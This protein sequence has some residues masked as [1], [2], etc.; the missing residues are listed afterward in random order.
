VTVGLGLV[1]TIRGLDFGTRGLLL[2]LAA[3]EPSRVA[4]ALA[5]EV[6]VSG[7]GGTKTVEA[8]EEITR[9]AMRLAKKLGDP[10]IEGLAMV[11]SG[12][13]ADL[14]GDFALGRER[15]ERGERILR[16]RCRGV[17][18]E[19]DTAITMLF[20]DLLFLGDWPEIRRRLPAA[21]EGFAAR[22]DLYAETNVRSRMAWVARLM[23]DQPAQARRE[24]TEAIARWSHKSFHLQHYWQLTGLAEIALYEG[25]GIAAWETVA[26]S[27]E[28]F[29]ATHLLRVQ[30]TRLEATHLRLRT[31]V[32]AMAE[33]GLDGELYRTLQPLVARELTRLEAEQI[34]WGEGLTLLLR[35]GLAA[36][37]GE[38]EGAAK[39]LERA[40]A[41]CDRYH[42]GLYGAAARL[43]LA[44]L[45]DN[46]EGD[47][48]R[49]AARELR[50]RGAARPDRWCDVL[51]PGG[52][53]R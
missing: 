25:R 35:A 30:F 53:G 12:M 5:L 29:T 26:A 17:T 39:L 1:D 7:T 51:V 44:N 47:R 16:E 3:G 24:A 34:A 23:Q 28:Q 49:A 8:T 20:R 11:T 27:W 46:G 48:A 37:E 43:R 18:W 45:R 36:L 50:E 33:S 6:G 2:A 41:G 40:A 14:R 32:A 52:W 13:G 10:R 4:R 38:Q 22:G 31:A 19:L 9:Q 21:L 15:L 42:L